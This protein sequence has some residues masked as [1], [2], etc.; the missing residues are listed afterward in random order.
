MQISNAMIKATIILDAR[1]KTSRGYPVK[2]RCKRTYINLGIYQSTKKLKYTPEIIERE[3]KL[4]QELAYINK[5]NLKF[6]DALKIIK[7]GVNDD[8]QIYLLEKQ[9]A[10]L[11]DTTNIGILEF[12][13]IIIKERKTKKM[14]VEFY[15]VTKVQ[16]ENFIINDEPINN[17]TYE[18]INYFILYKKNAPSG[19]MSYL[20]NLRT[21]YKE[22]Q[23]RKSYHIKKDN[24]FL[25]VIRRPRKKDIPEVTVKDIQKLF[26][27]KPNKYIS[28]A[29]AYKMQAKIDLWLFQFMIGGHDLI[30]VANLKNVGERVK[31]RRYKNRNK[32]HGGEL[33]DNFL[34]DE[35]KAIYKKYN[36]FD[37]LPLP[38]EYE[39]YKNFRNNYNR[40]LKTISQDLELT[41][42]LK[43]KT[44]R[45]TFRTFAGEMM[46]DTLV[47]MQLQGHKPTEVTFSYQRKLPAKIIDK[48]LLKVVKKVLN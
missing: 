6:E 4:R 13:D 29:N 20:T 35:A 42:I 36:G 2:I 39:K 12:Y 28:K 33:V 18:W 30:D 15:E 10:K 3:N 14:S 26:T 16:I 41:S 24:P 17:I 47:L 19:V 8:L 9:L 27:W 23:R 1:Y 48:E 22:A 43:S 25:N 37:F 38:G 5:N 11:K 21:V 46:I 40:T 45:Y 34:I 32:P 31:F 44:P 7:N